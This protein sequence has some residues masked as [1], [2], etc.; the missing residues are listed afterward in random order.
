MQNT[1]KQR[2][3]MLQ[4]SVISTLGK[5]HCLGMNTHLPTRGWRCG[6]GAGRRGFTRDRNSWVIYSLSCWRAKETRFVKGR[7]QYTSE[8]LSVWLSPVSFP[9]WSFGAHHMLTEQRQAQHLYWKLPSW[10]QLKSFWIWNNSLPW[11]EQFINKSG[12]TK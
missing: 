4:V 9:P 12:C 3:L 1:V 10:L 2:Y 5:R 7:A 11:L 6:S 8:V